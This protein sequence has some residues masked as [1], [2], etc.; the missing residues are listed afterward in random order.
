MASFSRSI[1]LY[2]LLLVAVS[3]TSVSVDDQG[4]TKT[5]GISLLQTASAALKSSAENGGGP[6][7]VAG[8]LKGLKD[9]IRGM[10]NELQ[11]LFEQIMQKMKS[12]TTPD[13]PSPSPSPGPPAP[14]PSPGPP[15]S[16]AGKCAGYTVDCPFCDC[17]NPS[18]IYPS[19]APG[20]KDWESH[21]LDGHN[22]LRCLH[23]VPPMRW[24]TDIAKKAQQWANE[25]GPRYTRGKN[26]H[27]SHSFRKGIAGHFMVGENIAWQSR[28]SGYKAAELTAVYSWYSEI[29]DTDQGRVRQ[30]NTIPS[31]PMIGHYTQQ[32]WKASVELGCGEHKK[33]SND[34]FYVC[35]YGPAGNMQGRVTG[36]V[37]KIK[38]DPGKC[39]DPR[40]W[41]AS[42]GKKHTR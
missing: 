28:W 24:N 3:A 41:A 9:D 16:S 7:G 15:P 13:L 39:Q 38:V 11:S 26:P 8:E 10:K 2:A 42:G 20:L 32:V 36:N 33:G 37:D 6:E 17:K 5:E 14:S 23:D 12:L 4:E 18:P 29:K 27:S 34:G 21:F 19:A 22:K 31:R 1:W 40:A 25:E 35:M 30:G